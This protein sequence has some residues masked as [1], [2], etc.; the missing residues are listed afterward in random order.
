MVPVNG[1]MIQEEATEIAKILNKPAEYDGFKALSGWLERWK[2][3]YGIT[4]V[5]I[6]A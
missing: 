1:L 5:I 6:L 3:W 4:V 2:R